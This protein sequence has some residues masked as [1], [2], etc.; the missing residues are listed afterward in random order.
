MSVAEELLNLLRQEGRPRCEAC[1][2]ELTGRSRSGIRNA[3]PSLTPGPIVCVVLPRLS[4]DRTDEGDAG[5][6]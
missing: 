3:C 5:P 2:S 4:L 1:L 6:R